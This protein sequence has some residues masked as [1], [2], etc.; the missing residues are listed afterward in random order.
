MKKVGLEITKENRDCKIVS[1]KLSPDSAKDSKD[2]LSKSRRPPKP[3]Y[4][5]VNSLINDYKAKLLSKMHSPDQINEMNNEISEM[6]RRVTQAFGRTAYT[7]ID[8]NN[9]KKIYSIQMIKKKPENEKLDIFFGAK[10]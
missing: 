8:K 6:P 7:F 4:D 5:I 1:L 2:G 10:G 9:E 3:K